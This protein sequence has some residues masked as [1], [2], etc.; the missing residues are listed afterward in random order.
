MADAKDSLQSAI[1]RVQADVENLKQQL[2]G[3]INPT[4]LDPI[5]QGLADLKTSLD[6]LDPD[7]SNPPPQPA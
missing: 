1:D 6:A 2:A 3:Q 7:P 5:S 4:D